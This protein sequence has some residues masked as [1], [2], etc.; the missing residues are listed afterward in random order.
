M[1]NIFPFLTLHSASLQ[2]YTILKTNGD[3]QCFPLLRDFGGTEKMFSVSIEH[4]RSYIV[5]KMK[6]GRFI[7]TK[8]NGLSYT[9]YPFL[10]TFELGNDSWGLLRKDDALRDY[11]NGIY[12]ES[13]GIKTNHMQCVFHID[14]EI[15]FC[16][17]P[18]EFIKPVILQ[19]DVE[20]PFRIADYNLCAKS[21]IDPYIAKWRETYNDYDN[22][23][24]IIAANVIIKNLRIM[25]D[26]EFLHNAISTHNYT[27]AL[28]LVDFEISSSKILPFENPQDVNHAKSLYHREI[29]YAYNIICSIALCLNEKLD[30][31]TLDNLFSFY[32][33]DLKNFECTFK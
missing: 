7:V 25:H 31:I 30:F 10:N 11:T 1:I 14:K 29:L 6:N 2:P 13:L 16:N 15:S 28:E 18:S 23:L 24:H 19:Y 26:N 12:V 20:C 8:G 5:A 17:N 4:G 9:K 22:P 27:W 33:F 3:C 21:L 32:G